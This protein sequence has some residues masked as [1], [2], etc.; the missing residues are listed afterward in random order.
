[1]LSTANYPPIPEVFRTWAKN[2]G[3][4]ILNVEFNRVDK[5]A[6]VSQERFVPFINS[7][8]SSE[9]YILYNYAASSSAGGFGDTT[10]TNWI[11]SGSEVEHSLERLTD[12][13]RWVVFNVQQTGER[14]IRRDS[15]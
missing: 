4:P 12:D 15:L 10:P 13:E 6:K 2:P 9:F 7:T 5:T 3:F 1:M 8:A 14:A 11:R